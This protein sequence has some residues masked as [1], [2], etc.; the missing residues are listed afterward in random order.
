MLVTDNIPRM[1]Y[2]PDRTNSNHRRHNDDDHSPNE[3]GVDTEGNKMPF[4]E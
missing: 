2:N 4:V 1:Q 3:S